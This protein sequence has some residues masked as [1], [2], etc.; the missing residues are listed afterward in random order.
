MKTKEILDKIEILFNSGRLDDGFVPN[1]VSRI[2][3]ACLIFERHLYRNFGAVTQYYFKYFYNLLFEFTSSIPLG[4]FQE[5]SSD[6][7]PYQKEIIL[8]NLGKTLE[9]CSDCE[10]SEYVKILI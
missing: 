1:P 6:L 7:E 8:R 2:L 9:I 10:L 5:F 3:N 4:K